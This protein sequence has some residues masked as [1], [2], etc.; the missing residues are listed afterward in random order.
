MT[1][2]IAEVGVKDKGKAGPMP[3]RFMPIGMSRLSTPTPFAT[4]MRRLTGN[5]PSCLMGTPLSCLL[6]SH[7]FHCR[8]HGRPCSTKVCA[9]RNGRARENHGAV[10]IR[11][12][13]RP[14]CG[15]MPAMHDHP[16]V[17]MHIA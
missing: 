6:T 9:A 7:E 12:D 3:R 13:V 1:G 10:R 15:G 17:P 8:S 11:E 14:Y 4:T 16:S 5:R 2:L